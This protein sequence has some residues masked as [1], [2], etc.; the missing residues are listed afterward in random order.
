VN[1]IPLSVEEAG[2][3]LRDGAVTSVALVE[4]CHARADAFDP[5]IGSYLARFD[6]AA[7]AAADTA[8]SE[9]A[10]GVDRGRC[11]ASRWA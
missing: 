6:D 9:L 8:D 2:A 10:A 1:D 3:A 5:A 7:L 4:A 11:T